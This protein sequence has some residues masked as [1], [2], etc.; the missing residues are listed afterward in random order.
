MDELAQASSST[1]SPPSR[2]ITGPRWRYSIAFVAGLLLTSVVPAAAFEQDRELEEKLKRSDPVALALFPAKG[3]KDGAAGFFRDQNLSVVPGSERAWCQ[4]QNRGVLKPGCYVE[5]FF[6]RKRLNARSMNGEPCGH[7]GRWYR[8][9]GS[10]TYVPTAGG[11]FAHAI[12][13]GNVDVLDFDFDAASPP[14][15]LGD[16]QRRDQCAARPRQ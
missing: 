2:D 16:A 5:F 1:T 8:A 14:V 6:H 9:T 13:V 4:V 7:L 3:Y 12:A 11:T 15:S 10:R